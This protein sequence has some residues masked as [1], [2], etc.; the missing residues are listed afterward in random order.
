MPSRCRRSQ[1][2]RGLIVGGSPCDAIPACAPVLIDDWIQ[3]PWQGA[4]RH[5]DQIPAPVSRPPTNSASGENIPGEELLEALTRFLL[6]RTGVAQVTKP[7][8]AS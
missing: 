3:P 6:L 4:H 1:R 8:L 5:S 2:R 7:L